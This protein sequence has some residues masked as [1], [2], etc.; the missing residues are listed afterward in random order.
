MALKER[1][2]DSFVKS[3]LK[4]L[5]KIF[6]IWREKSEIERNFLEFAEKAQ[7]LNEIS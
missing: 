5:I 4:N 7:K 2:E 3:Y 6:R 1:V